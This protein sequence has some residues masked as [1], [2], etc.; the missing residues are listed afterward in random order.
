MYKFTNGIVVFDEKTKDAFVKS[1]YKLVNETAKKLKK[2]MNTLSVSTSEL[3]E[4]LNE[5]SSNDGTI[6]AKP[7]RSK[8]V[9]E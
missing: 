2:Q 5:N 7:R 9:S 4:E 8:K 3:V 6:E 1:G